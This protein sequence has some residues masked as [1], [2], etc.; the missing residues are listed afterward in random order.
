MVRV[1]NINVRRW[2]TYLSP[3]AG[4][5][6]LMRS[7][8][9]ISSMRRCK[10]Y[11]SSCSEVM[12]A[13]IMVGR[14]IRPAALLSVASPQRLRFLRRFTPSAAGSARS[15][16]YPQAFCKK[17]GGL[18]SGRTATTLA[19]ISIGRIG[20]IARVTI[21]VAKPTTS[22]ERNVVGASDALIA[23]RHACCAC[24]EAERNWVVVRKDRAAGATR[25]GI[26]KV[27]QG[28]KASGR[29]LSRDGACHT[30]LQDDVGTHAR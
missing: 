24:C 10:V 13:W 29:S 18:T 28:G 4:T 12:F 1:R 8:W 2:E 26:S 27:Q 17:S 6:S 30:T 15:S 9:L 7:F 19:R 11:A 16:Q 3:S 25:L 14:P 21:T 22:S 23:P 5:T 20:S